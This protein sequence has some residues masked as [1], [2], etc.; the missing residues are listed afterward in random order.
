VKTCPRKRRK[1]YP[2]GIDPTKL[3]ER[4]Y[5]DARGKGRWYTVFEENGKSVSRKIAD[6]SA[7]M[8]ELHKIIEQFYKDEHQDRTSFKWLA[9]QF[10]QSA[11]Y[12]QLSKD[13]RKQYDYARSCV[14]QIKARNNKSLGDTDRSKWTTPDIQKIVDKM[15]KQRGPT[16]AKHIKQ[17]LSRLFNWGIN[18]GLSLSNPVIAIEL[19]KERKRRRLPDNSLIDRLISY[20]KTDAPHYVWMFLELNYL[21]LLR[22]VEARQMTEDQIQDQ[23]L[24]CTR[25]K[26]SKTTLFT[27]N[28]RLR[29]VIDQALKTRDSIWAKNKRPINLKS[30]SRFVFVNEAG[31]AISAS[32]WQSA[33]RRFLNKAIEQGLMDK[34]EWFGLHDMKRRGATDIQ[35]TK[36][37]KLE[38]TGHSSQQQLDTYDQSLT[39]VKPTSD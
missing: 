38:A 8:A 26:G 27:W 15:A 32:G 18:R 11:Q 24:K 33:W 36:A 6:K 20:A 30:E 5:Y 3:P 16:S 28:D 7:T 9:A 14:L 12:R 10:E 37:E 21:C 35:G 31:D 29:F 1:Q 17:Y 2:P 4:C 34:D 23:G 22:G 25:A 39:I 19:P 13:T